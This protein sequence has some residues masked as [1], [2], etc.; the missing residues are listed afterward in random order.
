MEV[1]YWTW[2]DHQHEILEALHA[3]KAEDELLFSYPLLSDILPQ[4]RCIIS[5]Q[6]LEIEPFCPPTDLVMA[7]SKAKRRIYMTATLADDSALVT[8]FAADPQTLANPIVPISSQSMGERMILM[9]QELNAELDG[10]QIR[11][12]L[13]TL[14]KKENVVVIVP[15]KPA[16]EPW[17]TVADQILLADNVVDGTA[18]LRQKHVGLTVLVNRYDGIDLPYDACRVL[19]IVGL[20]EVTSYTGLTDM[21]VLSDSQTGLRR[22]MQRIEQGMGR[23]VRSNDDY[24]VV[25]LIGAKLTARVKSP[26]GTALLTSATQAQ[27]DLSRKVAKQLAD[28]D[29]KGLKEVIDQCLNRDPDWARVSKKALLKA[30]AQP[31]LAIDSKSVTIR[32][33]FDLA[34]AGDH[35]TAVEVL[36]KAV[37]ATTDD[38]EKAWLLQRCAA[39]EHHISPA[40]S[41][42]TLLAAY[43]LNANVLRPLEGVAYQKL[44]AHTGAQAAAIQKFHQSR[45]L[46][47][48][49]RILYANPLI[50]DLVFHK[51]PADRFEGAIHSVAEFI[52]IKGQRPGKL[53]GEGPDNLWALPDGSFLVI[54]CKNNT[55][56]EN[57]IS[58]TDAGQLDQAMT[59]F[60]A[61]YPAA[62][63]IPVIIH[64][65]RKLGDGA[66]AVAGMRV[67]TEEELKK[68]RKALEAFTKA[69]SD[70]DTLNN[71]KKVKELVNTQGFGTEFLARYTKAPQ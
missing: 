39:I 50:D 45:F 35:K 25:L 57:G 64:P 43:R 53:F 38:D 34:R 55:T 68:L 7:F 54:E 5:G 8:H 46:E 2:I 28:V 13:V 26:E 20:P 17:K 51:V 65:H 27:L 60:G 22:Q 21:A 4:C 31:G 16:A 9:P 11:K 70:P 69:V 1:P 12:L 6:K 62:A 48:A 36:R 19:A 15:S 18:K 29:L 58:K 63:G 47:A 37:N 44:S 42:K 24:C 56:S 33:A 59:W 10:D 71:V 41:Q 49:D 3:H 66:T 40:E 61:K 23:G 32:T 14:A 67:M 30:K 52:G